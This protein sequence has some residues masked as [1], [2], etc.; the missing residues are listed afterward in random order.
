MTE[1][2]I[3][4]INKKCQGCG[5]N[6]TFNPTTGSL[7]CVQC[8]NEFDI[9]K[10]VIA[11][12]DISFLERDLTNWKGQTATYHCESCG[13]TEIIS[14][15][16]LSHECS[17]CGSPK[18]STVA[19]STV[20]KPQ[21]VQPFKVNKDNALQKAWE[22]AKKSFWSP[23]SFKNSITTKFLNGI[24]YP[25]FTFDNETE[26]YYK[27]TL[28]RTE[29]YRDSQG[30]MHTR[31][32]YFNVSGVHHQKFDDLTIQASDFIQQ[33]LIDKLLPFDTNNANVYNDDFLFGF[34]ASQ[35]TKDGVTC[36]KEAQVKMEAIIKA[37]ILKRYTYSSVAKYYQQVR[38]YNQT[39]KYLLLPIWVGHYY[40]KEKNFNYY[41]N[42]VNGKIAGN[43]PVSG[44]KVTIAILIGLLVIAAA[45]VIYYLVSQ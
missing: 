8:G 41:I 18:V 15:N 12:T 5:G 3:V 42:G 36:H 30:N 11:E 26:T 21:A 45:I 17:F 1:E 31:T 44:L 7:V 24:Y 4:E 6:L 14:K 13:A 33:K 20:K 23:K 2:T 32:V 10:E 38:Y 25:A 19:D 35:Y 37:N 9:E 16:Q 28:G 22:W 39:F 27:A 43:R 40:F 34:S 29:T